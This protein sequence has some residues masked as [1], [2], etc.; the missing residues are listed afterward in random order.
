M[1]SESGWQAEVA[2]LRARVEAL[3]A[4]SAAT[5]REAG[6]PRAARAP[7]AGDELW[8][9]DGLTARLPEGTGGVLLTGTVHLA[10]GGRAV[11]QQGH[12]VAA[13][14]DADVEVVARRLQALASEVRLRLL[15]EVLAGRGGSGDLAADPQFGTSGQ[16]Q[17]HLRLLVAAGWLRS[18]ARG[19]YAVPDERVVPLLVAMAAAGL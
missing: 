12:P 10:D 18:T 17:H 1:V 5:E 13:V 7:S 3:E 16:V 14:L 19:R 4:A 6:A 15:R 2:D 9:L 11:W 8:A